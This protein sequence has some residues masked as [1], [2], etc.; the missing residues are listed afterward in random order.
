MTAASTPSWRAPTAPSTAP[1]PTAATGWNWK[2][3]QVP[4][5]DETGVGQVAEGYLTIHP[6]TSKWTERSSGSRRA[7][8][9][10]SGFVV[11]ALDLA[12]EFI[13][14]I[15]QRGTQAGV[16][17]QLLGAGVASLQQRFQFRQ[18]LWQPCLSTASGAAAA[19]RR[20]APAG[21][22]CSWRY[23]RRSGRVPDP[24]AQQI[25][26]DG[27]WHRTG[28]AGFSNCSRAIAFFR[29]ATRPRVAAT[30]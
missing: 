29:K 5:P 8:G 15:A 21:L 20:R 22:R 19:R 10:Q 2:R 26:T 24:A 16:R 23:A 25:V 9:C 13:A 30:P 14:A 27:D 17:G 3:R 11:E 12:P 1:R 6:Q 4:E 28:A 18:H 7:Q